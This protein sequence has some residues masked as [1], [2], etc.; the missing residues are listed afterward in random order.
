[1]CAALC[2]R[3]K[4]RFLFCDAGSDDFELSSPHVNLLLFEVAAVFF[5]DEYEI[6][7]IADGEF[8][9]NV[10]VTRTDRIRREEETDGNR[11]AADRCAVHDLV[12]CDV[13]TIRIGLTADAGR[14]GLALNDDDLHMLDLDTDE[15]E[16]DLADDYVLQ[17]ILGLVVLELDVQTSILMEVFVSGSTLTFCTWKSRTF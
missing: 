12:L 15:Q 8:V 3:F 17:M 5:V 14:S 11:F 16:V 9:V 2:S 13:L 1:V 4:E 7:V 10:L 6:E